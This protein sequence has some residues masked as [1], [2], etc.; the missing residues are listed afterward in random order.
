[1]GKGLIVIAGMLSDPYLVEIEEG[2]I[3]GNDALIVSHAITSYRIVILGK[4]TIK[5][6]AVVGAKAIIMPGVTV[7]EN[8]MVT[9]GSIVTR[10]TIIP[11]NEVW[12]GNPAI[13]IKDIIPKE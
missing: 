10:D 2:V 11:P 3:I 13:K 8:S 6:G 4:I 12:G 1:M 9:M 5:K 7:G